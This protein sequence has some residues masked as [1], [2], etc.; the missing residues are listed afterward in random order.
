[1]GAGGDVLSNSFHEN[2]VCL[3]PKP[4][5]YEKEKVQGNLCHKNRCKTSQ[6]N[7]SRPIEQSVEKIIQRDYVGFF[8]AM[9]VGL[10]LGNQ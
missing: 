4:G 9:P 1:M 6:Q 7:D 2:T 5:R 8:L 3:I 10:I